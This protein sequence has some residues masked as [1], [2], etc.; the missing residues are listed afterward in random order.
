MIAS[1]KA[2]NIQQNRKRKFKKQQAPACRVR[3]LDENLPQDPRSQQ[4]RPVNYACLFLHSKISFDFRSWDKSA[5][6]EALS[7]S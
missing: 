2:L 6:C 5:V 4:R 3:S 1:R 7:V